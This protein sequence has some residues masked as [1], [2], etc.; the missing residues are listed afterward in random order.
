MKLEHTVT[1][2]DI[3]P[4]IEG[5]LVGLLENAPDWLDQYRRKVCPVEVE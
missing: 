1:K 5:V 4:T 3:G 2:N